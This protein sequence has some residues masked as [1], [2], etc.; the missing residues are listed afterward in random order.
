MGGEEVTFTVEN[1]GL[2][3]VIKEI[4]PRTNCEQALPSHLLRPISESEFVVVTQD[5]NEGS[6]LDFVGGDDGGI[7]FLRMDGRLYD[8]AGK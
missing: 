1:G 8:P 4:D 2:R 6:Q 3:R 5:E 7:R